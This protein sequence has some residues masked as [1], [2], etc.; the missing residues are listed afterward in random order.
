VIGRCGRLSQSVLVET[1][2]TVGDDVNIEN[3]VSPYCRAYLEGH[4]FIG[5]GA[6]CSRL[7]SRL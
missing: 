2:V 3:N 6:A 7:Y 5:A 1:G 4:V